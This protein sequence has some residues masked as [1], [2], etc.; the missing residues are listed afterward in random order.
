MKLNLLLALSIAACVPAVAFG[1]GAPDPRPGASTPVQ[2]MNGPDN[3]VPVS[4]SLQISNTSADPIPVI[5]AVSVTGSVQLATQ[6]FVQFALAERAFATGVGTVDLPPVPAGKRLVIEGASVYVNVG[7]AQ[8]I[9]LVSLLYSDCSGG[10]CFPKSLPL[11]CTPTGQTVN[12]LNYFW[13]C[14]TATR[15]VVQPGV[16]PSLLGQASSSGGTTR[17]SLMGWVAGYYVAVP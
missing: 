9:Q 15:M 7:N 17:I 3:P 6:E 13:V 10:I 4:G 5:G 16:T 11:A 1:Q 2:V 12:Q 8:G 14:S